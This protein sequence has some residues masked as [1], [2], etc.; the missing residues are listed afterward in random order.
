MILGTSTTSEHNLQIN[1]S[2][3]S[4]VFIRLYASLKVIWQELMSLLLGDS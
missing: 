1:L 4:F 2:V 3:T